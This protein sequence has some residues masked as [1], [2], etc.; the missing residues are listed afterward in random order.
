MVHLPRAYKGYDVAGIDE[1]EAYMVGAA[2]GRVQMLWGVTTFRS[3][4]WHK[5][6]SVE[7]GGT[8]WAVD[9]TDK[10]E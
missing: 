8:G 1:C 2:G 9:G 5:L 10:K 6:S 4:R 7:L 3:S